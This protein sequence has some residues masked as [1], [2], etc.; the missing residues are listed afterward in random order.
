[1]PLALC[2]I[3]F[4][5]KKFPSH[6]KTFV[7]LELLVSMNCSKTGDERPLSIQIQVAYR[8]TTKV[9]T[10]LLPVARE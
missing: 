5:L 8:P 6:Y 3:Q 4:Y 2:G 10:P 1:M 9:C 7:E